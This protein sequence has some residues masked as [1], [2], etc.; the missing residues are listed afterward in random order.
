MTTTGRTVL[1]LATPLL[2]TLVCACSMADRLAEVGS[3]PALAPIGN[4]ANPA[5]TKSIVYPIQL[6]AEV[7]PTANSLWRPGSK[8]FLKDQRAARVGDILTADVSVADRATMENETSRERS[9][10]D[11]LD[12]GSMFG[13]AKSVRSLLPGSPAFDPTAALGS[14]S[15]GKFTGTGSS[16][17]SETVRFKM[18]VV[19]V[20]QLRN[21]NFVISGKQEL[22]VNNELREVQVAGIV[23]P[24][25]IDPDNIVT[26]D[27]IAEARITYGGRGVLS[28]YQQPPIG[29]QIIELIRPF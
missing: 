9:N 22:R 4:V 10:S 26:S 1:R 5:S 23:R 15:Q 27:K 18:A 13:Y 2:A 16:A 7:R 12:L 17:R 29:S 3:P 21:G 20:D 11:A 19:I 25:D 6:E 24:Q 14:S 8:T 28:D